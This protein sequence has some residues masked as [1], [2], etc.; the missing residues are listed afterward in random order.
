MRTI[1][2][3]LAHLLQGKHQSFTCLV[4][5]CLRVCGEFAS[6]DDKICT[7]W[8]ANAGIRARLSKFL[9]RLP[10]RKD[11]LVSSGIG[12]IVLFYTRSTQPQLEIKRMA[13]RLVGEWSRMAQAQKMRKGTMLNLP[14]WRQSFPQILAWPFLGP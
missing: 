3:N 6:R 14:L 10:V 7:L 5:A 4:H 9:M 8:R 12:K 1:I 2:T 11:T 13:E